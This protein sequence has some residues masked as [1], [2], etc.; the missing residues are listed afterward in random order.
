MGYTFKVQ[1]YDESKPKVENC[2]VKPKTTKKSK[3]V[4]GD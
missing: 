4:K 1:T 3:K 2:E